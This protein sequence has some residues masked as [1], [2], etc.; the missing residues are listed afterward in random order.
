MKELITL[1]V[2]FSSLSLT[3]A[4][5][6]LYFMDLLDW[7]LLAVMVPAAFLAGI[8]A[9]KIVDL[10][11]ERSLKIVFAI[12]LGILLTALLHNILF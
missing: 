3:T 12:S 1:A 7:R 8:I 9:S 5:I 6:N 11:S 2:L 10:V 4:S